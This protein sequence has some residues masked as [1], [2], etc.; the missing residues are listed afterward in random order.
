MSYIVTIAI[1]AS[2]VGNGLGFFCATL[3]RD[4]DRVAPLTNIVMI[5]LLVLSGI[6]NKLGTMPEWTSW[7]QYASPFRYGTHLLMENQF[8]DETFGGNYDYK[9]DLGVNLSYGSNFL[10]LIGLGIFFYVVS[11]LLLKFFT[12]RIAA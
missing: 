4:I 10:S 3:F 6:F 8:G 7:M 11:F 9:E 2:F 12:V 1:S 5:P